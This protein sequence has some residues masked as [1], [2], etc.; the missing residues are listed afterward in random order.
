MKEFV[1][2][3]GTWERLPRHIREMIQVSS[4]DATE[5]YFMN[6]R[7]KET[8][9]VMRFKMYD[10]RYDCLMEAIHKATPLPA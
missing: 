8:V 5:R 3:S 9:S 2:E 7:T 4:L 10:D 6:R 1:I